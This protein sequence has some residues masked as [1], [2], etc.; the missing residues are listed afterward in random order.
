MREP[1]F[2]V[3]WREVTALLSSPPAA[4]IC[5]VLRLLMCNTAHHLVEHAA[6]VQSGTVCS[7]HDTN[8][9]MAVCDD[10]EWNLRAEKTAQSL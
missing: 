5:M 9:A 10:K 4:A 8:D 6:G 1:L 2:F 7:L 3:I